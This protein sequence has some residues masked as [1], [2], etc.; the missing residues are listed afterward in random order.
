MAKY[1]FQPVRMESQF[2][3]TKLHSVKVWDGSANFLP[4]TNGMIV[5]LGDFCPEE[6]YT[7]QFTA[8]GQ[9]G[10][11]L[12]I[13]T[14]YATIPAAG[15]TDICV[16]DLSNVP[17]ATN[18]DLTYRIGVKTTSLVAEA[19]VPVRAR[20]LVKDD[21]FLAGSDTFTSTPTKGQ[22]AAVGADGKWAP[23]ATAPATGAYCKV[24]DQTSISEGVTNAVTAYRL[25]VINNVL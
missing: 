15:A 10:N 17:T 4:C 13:N 1:F 9:S 3:P 19:N 11:I 18:N 5:S 8:A 16:I 7:T 2:V 6:V 12:D 25:L 20:K 24:E 21:Y 14:R 23:A 22:F